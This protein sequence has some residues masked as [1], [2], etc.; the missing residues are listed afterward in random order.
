M[1]YLA[2]MLISIAIGTGLLFFSKALRKSEGSDDQT[3][4]SRLKIGTIIGLVIVIIGGTFI[5][6][7]NQIPAGYIGVV[8][9]FGSIVE[10]VPEG[11]QFVRPWATVEKANLQITSHKFI[12]LACFSSETQAVFVDATL[13]I[14]VSPSAIQNLYR[15]VGPNWFNVIVAPRLSQHFKDE[16]VKYTS[17]GIAPNR[18][19][20]RHDVTARLEK[21]CS[22]SSIEVTDL[23][24][25]DIDFD[26]NFKQAIEKKQIATQ[27]ALEEEQR[28][29]GE[30]HKADQKIEAA[31][32]E[33][34]SILVV[35]SK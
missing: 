6:S 33:G 9:S 13:N 31:R 24:L 26:P 7:F 8:Y 12:K 23:L 4:G 30:R 18:E 10:Q 29:V 20:I 19:R 5:T 25:E 15:T 11:A 16:T 34:E 1:F 17:V 3:F 32:G 2:T 27:N 14:R 22:P 35:A 28:V 21:D